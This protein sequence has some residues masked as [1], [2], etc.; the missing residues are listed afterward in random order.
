MKAVT[1]SAVISSLFLLVTTHILT[2]PGFHKTHQ[3]IH[4]HVWQFM[5]NPVSKPI[6]SQP[7][8]SVMAAWWGFSPTAG[9]VGSVHVS[10]CV[11]LIHMCA[12]PCVFLVCIPMC[13]CVFS[14]DVFGRITVKATRPL[15]HCPS[16]PELSLNPAPGYH[17]SSSLA[18]RSNITTKR[19]WM[20]GR[21]RRKKR[22]VGEYR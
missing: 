11:S 10:A 13:C 17:G 2:S 6:V 12:H 16:S 5:W 14:E 4:V 1:H 19:N 8:I 22:H 18:Y 3:N 21:K 9:L 20:K 7:Y 15:T